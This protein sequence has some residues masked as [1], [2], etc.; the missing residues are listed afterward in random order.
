MA[1]PKNPNKKPM[2]RVC[3][4]MDGEIKEGIMAAAQLEGIDFSEMLRHFI[5]KGFRDYLL[6]K[7]EGV[8]VG[9]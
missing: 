4:S 7:K 1:R 5:M 8:P 3:L 6:K 2:A 9:F